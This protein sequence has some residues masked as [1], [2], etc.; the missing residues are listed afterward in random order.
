MCVSEEVEKRK[1]CVVV[2]AELVLGLW[3]TLW[4]AQHTKA[5]LLSGVIAPLERDPGCQVGA[6]TAMYIALL[7]RNG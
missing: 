4:R 3:K 7:F 6:S 2:E 5:E 1:M